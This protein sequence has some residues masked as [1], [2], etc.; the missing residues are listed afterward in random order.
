MCLL[1]SLLAAC[2]SKNMAVEVMTAPGMNNNSPINV[3]IVF[4][5]DKDL[6]TKLKAMS[7]SKWFSSEQ[8]IKNDNPGEV[9][10]VDWQVIP[11]QSLVEK[12]ITYTTSKL[13]GILV[14]ANYTTSGDH[15]I[16]SKA[17]DAMTII[18]NVKDFTVLDTFNDQSKVSS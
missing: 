15:R 18:M 17:E 7:A 8:Q 16:V 9:A 1:S 13:Q 5:Y 6:M 3:A 14:Y 4:A 12:Q 11:D 10:T 2:G